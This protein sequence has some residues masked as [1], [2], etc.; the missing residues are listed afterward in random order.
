[1]SE[2]IDLEEATVDPVE[3]EVSEVMVEAVS[4]HVSTE[5]I[6]GGTR[7]TITDIDGSYDFDVMDGED[8]DKGD[9]GD[10]GYS[11]EA[12]VSKSGDTATIT[13]TDKTGTTTATITDGDKGDPADPLTITGTARS[14]GVTDTPDTMPSSWSSTVPA[15]EQGEWLWCRTRFAFSDGTVAYATNC[16]YQGVDGAKGD[17]GDDY[18]LTQADKQ[19]IAGMVDV[20]GKMDEPTTEG[21]SGQVLTTDGQGGRSWTS[22]GGETITLP[23]TTPSITGMAGVRYVCGE[24]ATLDVIAPATGCIDVTFTSGSTP[25]ALTVTSAKANTTI[26]WANGF[27]PSSLDADTVYEINVLNGEL[28]VAGAWS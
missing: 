24:C 3:L 25:T 6:T 28:G 17:P 18:V 20:S 23:G 4:P 16:A 7:V 14:W 12:S 2:Y 1:M 9:P 5:T 19:E 11:P 10:D 13:I 21:T 22:V 8:G 27:D 26:K 15:V